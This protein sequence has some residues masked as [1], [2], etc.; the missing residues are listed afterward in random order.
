MNILITGSAGFIGF[1]FAKYFLK[2]NIT[3]IGIDNLNNYYSPKLKKIRLSILKKN[4]NFIFYKKDVIDYKSLKKIF[5]N[6]NI[7]L[8][9]HFAYIFYCHKHYKRINYLYN[10]IFISFTFLQEKWFAHNPLLK[11]N[12]QIT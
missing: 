7:T 2:K 3:V 6:H 8:I 1:H 4:K 12:L 9:Y 11:K 5:S 10:S